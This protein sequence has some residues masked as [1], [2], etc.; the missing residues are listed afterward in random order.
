MAA[1]HVDI[2]AVSVGGLLAIGKLMQELGAAQPWLA[3][4]SYIAA[5]LVAGV[6]IY[7]KIKNKGK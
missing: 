1:H 5:I 4:V 2:A 6:T 3:S 7:Y